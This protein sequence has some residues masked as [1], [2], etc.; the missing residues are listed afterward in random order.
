VSAGL[1]EIGTYASAAVPV[2]LSLDGSEELL[3]ELTRLLGL[4]DGPFLVLTPT[5]DSWSAEVEALARP[6]AGGHVSLSSVLIVDSGLRSNGAIEPM[7]ADYTKRVASLRDGG[8]TL[9]SIHREIAAVRKDFGELRNAKQ[10]LEKMLADGM[11]AFTQKVDAKSFQ[12]FCT[13]LAE[14]DVSKAAR[15]LGM[16]DSTLRDLLR[17]WRGRGGAYERMLDVVR[18]RK[19]VGRTET[20]PLNDEIILGRARAT[21]YP[22]VLSEVLDGLLSMTQTNWDELSKELAEVLKAEVR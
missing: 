1:R 8:S 22:A 20:V 6:H 9:R 5:G 7:L 2:C 4:R 21:D 15:T 10:Q 14:G 18:W 12:A 16:G 13:I 11:F 17:E 3:R 19:S